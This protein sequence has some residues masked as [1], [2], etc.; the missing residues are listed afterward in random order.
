VSAFKSPPMPWLTASLAILAF[1]AVSIAYIDRPLAIAA[2]E[3]APSLR[4][5]FER[6]T[7]LGDSAVYLVPT[8]AAAIALYAL[9][10]RKGDAARQARLR[11]CFFA[12]LFLFLAVAVSGLA[13]DLLKILFGRP[14]PS[15]FLSEGDFGW[16]PFTLEARFRGFPSGHANTVVSMALAVGFLLP[17]ARIL[18]LILAALV[19]LTRIAVEA[20]YLSDIVAGSSLAFATTIWLRSTFAER[21]WLFQGSAEAPSTHPDSGC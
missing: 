18:L 11:R 5:V 12:A 10:R 20:H 13:T 6:I 4:I 3:L 16:H 9:E 2:S 14:R 15:L 7:V 21:G 19:A 8:G 1:I 17:R